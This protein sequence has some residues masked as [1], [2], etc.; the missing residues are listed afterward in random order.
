MTF[1]PYTVAILS[2]AGAATA[3]LPVIESVWNE[4]ELFESSGEQKINTETSLTC[5]F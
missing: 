5:V 3:R 2:K 4:S 1:F